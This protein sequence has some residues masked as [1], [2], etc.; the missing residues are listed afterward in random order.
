MIDPKEQPAGLQ[1]TLG[2]RAPA[3]TWYMPA[4]SIEEGID[5][6]ISIMN[7]H[8]QEALVSISLVTAEETVQP[9]KLVEIPVAPRTTTRVVLAEMLGRSQ[10]SLGGAG[11]IVR[12]T[13]EVG[14]IAERTLWYDLPAVAGTSSEIGAAVARERWV[15]PPALHKP[16]T[17]TLLILNPGPEPARVSVAVLRDRGDPQRPAYLTAIRV[18]PA[19]RRRIEL[20]ELGATV[21]VGADVPV[22]A[23]RSAT[24][25]RDAAA[26]LGVPAGE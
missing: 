6:R 16:T 1:F 23:E 12:S 20:R 21:Y 15:V 10:S 8:R 13:N 26:V 4:G 2:A 7:P 9:P 5:A 11:V 24:A 14:V 3:D 18:P 17:D 25:G 19:T 22:V